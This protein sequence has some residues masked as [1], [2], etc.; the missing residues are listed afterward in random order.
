VLDYGTAD[1]RVF[2]CGPSS[3]DAGKKLGGD[4]GVYRR[5]CEEVIA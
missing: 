1:E 3:K 5:R 2:H 4:Y